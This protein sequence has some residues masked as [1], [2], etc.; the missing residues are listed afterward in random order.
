MSERRPR[1]AV[2]TVRASL[3]EWSAWDEEARAEGL[4]RNTWIRRALGDAVDLARVLRSD[5]RHVEEERGRLHRL[6][7]APKAER[8]P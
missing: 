6:A 3:E 2:K 4:T 8:T 5:A 7:F 1:T